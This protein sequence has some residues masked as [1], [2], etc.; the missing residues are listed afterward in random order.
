MKRIDAT[1]R[2]MLM[3][4]LI[5]VLAVSAGAAMAQGSGKGM[6]KARCGGDFE[7]RGEMRLARLAERLDL[8]DEQVTTITGIHEKGRE[9]NLQIRKDMMRLRNELKGEMLKDEP[10]QKKVLELNGQL[11]DLR[12]QKQAN[13]LKNRLAVREQLT[14]EQRDSMLLMGERGEGRRGDRGFG[15][16]GRHATGPEGSDRRGGARGMHRGL[17]QAPDCPRVDD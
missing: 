16:G 17:G 12:T 1:N 7:S 13:R 8:T 2:K 6:G 10:S 3:I 9:E 4:A 15:R 11:G 5:A 14:P